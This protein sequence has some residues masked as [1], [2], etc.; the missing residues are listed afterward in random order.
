MGDLREK[1]NERL[2]FG[3]N[4][5]ILQIRTI[6]TIQRKML[7]R[8]LFQSTLRQSALRRASYS[9]SPIQRMREEGLETKRKRLAWQSRKRGITECDL[10][11]STFSE[12]Y[13][14]GMSIEEMLAYDPTITEW[15]LY[16]WFT[17][18]QP[19]PQEL[20]KDESF[21]AE[22]AHEPIEGLKEMMDKLI[23]HSKNT[24]REILLQPGL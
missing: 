7:S 18:A 14:A 15:D 9:F 1:K 24:K 23:E 6:D 17:E 11:L 13:L 8:T 16:Y 3:H 20:I 4:L 10:I 22:Y 19:Y 5:A 12:K 2:E 21:T